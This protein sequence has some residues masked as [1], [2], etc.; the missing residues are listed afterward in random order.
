MILLMLSLDKCNL[1]VSLNHKR[2]REYLFEPHFNAIER[3]KHTE[4]FLL[5]CH[6]YCLHLILEPRV[7]EATDVE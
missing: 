1:D 3:Q 6:I 2:G 4:E 7:T 5:L